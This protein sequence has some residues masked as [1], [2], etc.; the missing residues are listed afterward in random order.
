MSRDQRSPW[1]WINLVALAALAGISFWLGASRF[2][3]F[4][5][6][7]VLGAIASLTVTAVYVLLLLRF[8]ATSRLSTRERHQ[9]RRF[10][11]IMN[12]PHE[13]LWR[14]DGEG[15]TV[16]VNRR[17]AE[18]LGYAPEELPGRK[19]SD[20]VHEEWAATAGGIFERIR[21]GESLRFDCCLK[22]RDGSPLWT[23]VASHTDL[24]AQGR[25]RGVLGLF[26]DVSEQHRTAEAQAE[27]LSLLEATL[28]STADG[29]LVVDPQ[30]RIV[31]LN[32]RFVR[33]W[34]IP[35]EIV[36][37]RDD[38]QAL[39]F[40]LSQLA[41]PEQF[42]SKVRELYSKPDEESFDTL[43]FKDGRV[44]E[45]YS[46]PQL[47]GSA[48]VG[49]VWSFRDV[50][51]RE[52]AEAE[53]RIAM[54]RERRIAQN[55][56]AALFRF[57]LGPDLEIRK[58]EHFSLGAELLFGVRITDL[59]ADPRFWIDRIHPDD[60]RDVVRPALDRLLDLQRVVID[61]RYRTSKDIYRW[62]RSRL[63]P[64]T[65]LDGS[66]HVDGLET[67]VTDRVALEE[68]LRH[69]QKMEAVGQLAGGIAHDF[70]N[71]LTA[72]LG[73]SDLLLS[74]LPKN[75]PS[76]R[77]IEEIHKG[78][79]RAASL[80]RQLL[81]FGRRAATTPRI[82]D[83]NSSIR[84]LSPMLHRVVGEDIAFDLSLGESL[85]RT[86]IDP[87][88]LEQALVNLVVNARDAMPRGGTI[89]IATDD[90]VLGD[91]DTE[92]D[93][94]LAP[95][96][97]VRVIVS[98][99]GTGVPREVAER[100]FEPFFTTKEPGRG[101]GLGLATA[102]G[103]VRQHGG[104]IRLLPG[105]GRGASFEIVLPR[106][107]GEIAPSAAPRPA[108]VQGGRETI[109]FVEDETDLVALG[110][111]ILGMYGYTVL[112][113]GTGEQA[114]AIAERAGSSIDLVITDVV[115]PGMGGRELVEQLRRRN[116]ALQALFVSGYT[117][118]TVLLQG[119]E[120]AEFHFLEKPYTP[121][122][123]AG[124]VR[125]ILNAARRPLGRGAGLPAR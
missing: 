17:L 119:V 25:L 85:G 69:A 125:E 102:Y 59:Q 27:A 58:Y 104:R 19:W 120:E 114:I 67:D 107:E 64:G 124:K 4:L 2:P 23:A 87:S 38:N 60:L 18:M 84:E 113:A 16:E 78:G 111:E 75:D 22:R 57:T 106:V 97:Y 9:A 35:P 96:P 3:R 82:L 94:D 44:F 105:S 50:T 26:V 12:S 56:D 37:T 81:A 28:E 115:M 86:R 73:Y 74:R 63:I 14:F 79:E 32:D 76:R 13:G 101:T 71:I 5:H 8:R 61:F 65:G 123:L 24:D 77:S 68:Q 93:P 21:R 52:R 55:L 29:I 7:I 30:G 10:Q 41:E 103:I 39:A 36:E 83:L 90:V 6:P 109:L 54:E 33:M 62:H 117:R 43:R 31:R 42:L 11:D 47:L 92:A 15:N 121:Q 72:I 51:D 122:G 40:V 108:E 46:M 91:D 66:I 34:R 100:I 95:G 88:Q 49:R 80:T 118:D 20:F 110:R 53:A 99:T 116:P 89:R 45:R 112:T 48:I 70:N 1:T 98:D